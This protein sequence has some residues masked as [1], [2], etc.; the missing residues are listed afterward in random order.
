MWFERICQLQR[1]SLSF[2][3]RMPEIRR[4]SPDDHLRSLNPHGRARARVLAELLAVVSHGDIV[5]SLYSRC[6]ETVEPLAEHR[7]RTVS[8]SDALAEGAKLDAMV[9][10]LHR[11]PDGSVACAHGN[12]LSQLTDVLLD[13]RDRHEQPISFDKGGV[14]V[15]SREG[16][17]LSIVDEMRR[18]CCA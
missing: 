13:T 10:L 3:T 1:G 15:L 2:A 12:M 16:E 6:V 5:S 18:T 17:S 11:L 4:S 9:D 14:W 7:G 8:I